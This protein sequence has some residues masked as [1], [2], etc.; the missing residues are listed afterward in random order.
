[1]RKRKR[2]IM[3]AKDLICKYEKT[4]LPPFSVFAELS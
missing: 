2:L 3:F 4:D 1:M